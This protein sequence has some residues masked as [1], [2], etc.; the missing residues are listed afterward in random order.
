[1]LTANKKSAITLDYR[2]S[3]EAEYVQVGNDKIWSP[4]RV[5]WNANRLKIAV[6]FLVPG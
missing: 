3:E 1:M 2:Q 5:G 4:Y 6:Y